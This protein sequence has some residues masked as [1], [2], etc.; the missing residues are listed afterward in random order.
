MKKQLW[1]TII[2]V[3]IAAQM[4]AACASPAPAPTAEPA[5]A[6]AVPAT[7]AP[8]PPP[9][10]KAPDPTMAPT[11]VADKTAT[12]G[13][14]E[15]VTS[16]DP[17][18]DW[19]IA[20]TWIHMN[21][22]DCLVW[23]NRDTAVF[24]PWLA[25]SYENVTDTTWRFKLRQGVTFHNGEPFNADAVL[26]TFDR[27][28]A[29]DTMITHPQWT[30][31][32]EM[33]AV[34]PYTV[35]FVTKLPEPA[36]LS[37]ISGTGCGIQAPVAGKAQQKSGADYTPVGTGPFM[38]SEWVKDDYIKLVSN[39]TYWQGKPGID[40]LLFRA[41]PETSTQV[42]S[43]IAGDIDLMVG[44]PK[45]DWERVNAN[46]STS[47]EEYLTNRTLLLALRIGPSKSMPD[48]TGPTSDLLV[49][50]AISL[51]ID[52]KTIMELI[53][54]LGIP[55]LS[56]ITP[57][58][59]GW[60]DKFFDQLG[61]YNPVKARELL[62]KSSYKGEPLTFHSSTATLYEKEVAQAVT[63]MLQ[64]IGLNMDSQIMELTA[65]REKIYFPNKNEELYMTAL[66][67][68]FFDPWITVKEFGAGQ[69]QRN[70][71]VNAE[72]D[73]LIEEA[74]VNMDPKA[75][76]GQYLKVQELINAEVPHV[77]LYLQKDALGKS[78]RLDFKI[79]VDNF[80]WMGFSKIN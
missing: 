68:S 37:K 73:K 69:K 49:R 1:S 36:M 29:D 40:T 77:Y 79:N 6:A 65:Y 51:A 56:R 16:L 44:V 54:G 48:W 15:L 26:W 30:F 5:A 17:P 25:E 27:I 66:G 14:V 61:E 76:A 3:V 60:S 59:L 52:R 45:Q 80:L 47:V 28:L 8:A 35:D 39:P 67:N 62:A 46:E 34:D 31:I 75:R 41:I 43:L 13:M 21:I 32:Q 18:T 33:K 42:A 9:A 78:K 4:L 71:W 74:G 10:T 11:S 63:A 22:F 19:T 70:G 58:T 72:V 2:I 57:P 38:L 64:D 12:I 53:D 50:Q 7:E 20:A 23:R 55:T 24:E